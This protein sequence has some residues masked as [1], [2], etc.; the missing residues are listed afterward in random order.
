MINNYK[1][2]ENIVLYDEVLNKLRDFFKRRDFVEVNTQDRLSIL[3]ACEDPTTVATFNY[4]GDL[5]P[6]PQTG[7]MWLEYELLKRPALAEEGRGV[8]CVSTSF[9]NEQKPIAGRHKIIFPMFEFEAAGTIDDLRSLEEDVLSELGFGT[10]EDFHHK[11]YDE[12]KEYYGV[13]DLS[14][15]EENKM[16]EDFGPVVFLEKFPISTSPFWN[17]KK[18]EDYAHK[19]DVILYGNETIG[20]AERSTNPEEMREQF[21][22]ISAGNYAKKLYELFGESR[23]KIE[24]SDFLSLE[25]FPRFGGGIGMTRLMSA[26]EK[27]KKPQKQR[28][29]TFPPV[30]V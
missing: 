26:Y 28:S 2:V 25:F 22:T 8:F 10:A 27:M 9:R 14:H 18:T 15:K 24:L 13:K 11:E 23:V 3:A 6:L 19:I 12:L 7:Q 5:W 17:M 4:A 16:T 20:S 30:L 21:E 1:G 29:L